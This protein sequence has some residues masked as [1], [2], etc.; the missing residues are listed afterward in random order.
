MRWNH[1]VAYFFGGAFLANA[2]LEH[3]VVLRN[4]N[5]VPEHEIVVGLN[6]KRGHGNVD[7]VPLPG[8]S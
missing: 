8:G 4:P 7:F 6:F 3:R 5:E 2:V 1:T